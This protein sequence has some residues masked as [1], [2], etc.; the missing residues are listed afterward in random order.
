MR[1]VPT[2]RIAA[3]AA[4]VLGLALVAVV[5]LGGGSEYV[6]KARFV[7]AGQLVK[8]NLVQVAGEPVGKVTDIQLTSDNQAELTLI[9]LRW[10]LIQP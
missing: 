6:I 8:G 4:L 1:G 9:A 10:G 7:D 5:T 3:V 2:A